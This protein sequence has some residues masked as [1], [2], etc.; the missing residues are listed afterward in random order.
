MKSMETKE[1][2]RVRW[3][4]AVRPTEDDLTKLEKIFGLH[5]V[6]VEEL[7]APSVRARVEAYEGY[8][9]FIYYFPIYDTKN[10]V[11]VRNEIDFIV[12]KDTVATVHYDSFEQVLADFTIG[13]APDSLALLYHLVSHLIMF[14]ERQLRHIREKV[15]AISKKIFEGKEKEILERL[16][17][18]K[19]DISEYR[20]SV[21][22][23][24]PI[25]KSLAAKGVQFW[26]KDA[27]IYLN[28]L[29]GEQ[30]KVV[31]QVQDYRETVS[32]YEDTN[33]QLM[34]MKI[35]TAMKTFTT[36]S[37]LTFPFMLFAALFS[38]NTIDT[39]L[40]NTPYGFWIIVGT[41]LLGMLAMT[42]YFKKKDWF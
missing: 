32:D 19:R 30:L 10:E 28:E 25:L 4:D 35:N 20:I 1:N 41:I 29:V 24:E 6:V 38:M 36:L 18:L 2:K 8:L 23:Q 26:G 5:P 12:T 3:I 34:N 27:E 31:N 13:D 33:D 17:Y 37:F 22:L 9:Y 21:R 42:V 39:P 40:V 7:R 14:E 15:E 11:S 16:T